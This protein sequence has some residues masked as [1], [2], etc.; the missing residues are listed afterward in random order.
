M[1]IADRFTKNLTLQDYS[2]QGKIEGVRVVELKRSFRE[3]S[4]GLVEIARLDLGGKLPEVSDF[5]VRQITYTYLEPGAIKAWH[6]HQKQT[7][8]WFVPPTTR[9]LLGLVDLR[10]DSP[11]KENSMRFLG[12][13][14]KSQLILVPPGVAHGTA[15]PYQNLAELIYLTSQ[16]FDPQDEFRLSWDY[17]GADF[18]QLH[19]S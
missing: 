12:G 14:G 7:D 8:L 11:S 2:P 18:W 17:F 9:L 16:H 4:G 15:N 13:G 6:V 19:C 1:K 5:E 10:E 3:E